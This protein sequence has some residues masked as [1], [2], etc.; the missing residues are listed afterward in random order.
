MSETETLFA[1]LRQLQDA[2]AVAML[3]RM[4]LDAPDRGVNTINALALAA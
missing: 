4:V 3:G 1:A 2:D